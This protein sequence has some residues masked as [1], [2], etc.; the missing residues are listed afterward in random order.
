MFIV[1]M[2]FFFIFLI[3]IQSVFNALDSIPEKLCTVH[4]DVLNILN[5][6]KA[7]DLYISTT[8]VQLTLVL[9]LF[10]MRLFQ[11]LLEC[12]CIT[13]L[14]LIIIISSIQNQFPVLGYKIL[15]V[16]VIKLVNFTLQG[17]HFLFYNRSF[18]RILTVYVR[19]I[20]IVGIPTNFNRIN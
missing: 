11:Y 8:K 13:G 16:K 6:F 4:I 17:N 20:D 15:I 2:Q 14:L 5:I 9:D 12:L 1:R 19:T 3:I 18:Y 10:F 7:F